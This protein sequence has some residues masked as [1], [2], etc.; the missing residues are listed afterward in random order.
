MTFTL[1]SSITVTVL[2]IN[3]L[4]VDSLINILIW[5]IMIIQITKK[6]L[7]TFN[8]IDGS[9]T[10]TCFPQFSRRGKA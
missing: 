2:I 4:S 7:A 3:R 8:G 5:E 9:E 1:R 10:V 6:L